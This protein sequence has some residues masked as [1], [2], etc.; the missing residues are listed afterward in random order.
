MA[1]TN[2]SGSLVSRFSIYSGIIFSASSTVAIQPDAIQPDFSS[3]FYPY[4]GIY[5]SN[6][7]VSLY[8]CLGFALHC[9]M[10]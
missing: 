2:I 4:M 1:Q 7:E 10:I 6:K 8:W 3:D 5:Q 9:R